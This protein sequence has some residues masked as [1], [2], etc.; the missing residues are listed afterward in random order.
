MTY[1]EYHEVV[2]S[3]PKIW[4]TVKASVYCVDWENDNWLVDLTSEGEDGYGHP[5]SMVEY[6]IHTAK[7]FEKAILHFSDFSR[8]HIIIPP[9]P[10]LYDE[11]DVDHVRH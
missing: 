11:K 1:K 2:S 3:L 10:I 7:F 4:P 9:V 5:V 6:G 8:H